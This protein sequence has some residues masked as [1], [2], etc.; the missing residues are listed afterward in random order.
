MLR[1]H[2]RHRDAGTKINTLAPVTGFSGDSAIVVAHDR[3]VAER[4]DDARAVGGSESRESGDIEVVVMGVRDKDR[5]D[6]RQVRKRNA[7]IV[8]PFGPGKTHGRS[9]LRPHRIDEQIEARGLQEKTGVADIGDAPDCPV[10]ARR[11]TIG[12]GR[13]GPLRPFRPAAPPS[14]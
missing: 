8:H 10:D 13:R 1:R 9:A 3:V 14:R 5:I 2:Q 6:W 12:K 7:R 11:R 4:G